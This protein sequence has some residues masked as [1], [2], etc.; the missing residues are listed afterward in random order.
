MTNDV[1]GEKL[2]NQTYVDREGV[3]AVILNDK[4]EVATVRLP[5]GYFLPGGGLEGVESKEACLRRECIEELGWNIEINQFV[6][7]ASNYYYSNYRH[8]YLHA[9]G[10]FYL[11]TKLEQIT[12]P[13]ERDHELVWLSLDECLSQLHLDHQAWAVKKAMQLI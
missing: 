8:L 13:I 2:V 4:N 12:Q 7:K 3:Y 10:H 1:F 9:T 6:C 5:H 11:A